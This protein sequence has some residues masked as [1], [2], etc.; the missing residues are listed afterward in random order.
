MLEKIKL[1]MRIQHNV[2]DSNITNNIASC[3]LDLQRV[4]VDKT[5]AVETSE[6]ALIGKAA[7]L[8]C[9][10]Q[11]DFG[12]KGEQFMKAYENLRDAISL[13][14]SYAESVGGDV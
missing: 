9:K 2:L 14:G 6:D 1:S 8:Y 5:F 11:F 10:W 4:G 13:C 3:M 7:E 12:G